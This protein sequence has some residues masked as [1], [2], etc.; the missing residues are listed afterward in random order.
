MIR[1]TLVEAINAQAQLAEL[2]RMLLPSKTSWRLGK[3]LRVVNAE[4]QEFAEARSKLYQERGATTDGIEYKITPE[5]L[6][7]INRE[8]EQ[9]GQEEIEINVQKFRLEDF[10]NKEMPGN[11]FAIEWLFEDEEEKAM[12][13]SNG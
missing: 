3:I 2:G 11:C 10:G 7:E 12:E 13:A 9:L 6:P 5:Q 1:I 4:V 8:L